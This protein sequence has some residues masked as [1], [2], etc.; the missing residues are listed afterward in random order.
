M[1]DVITKSLI[2][3]YRNADKV[4]N[5]QDKGRVAADVGQFTKAIHTASQLDNALGKGA[6]AA[7]SA[8]KNISQENK[9]LKYAAK[10]AK[11]ASQN[12]NPLLIGA[13][14]YRVLTAEDKATALRKETI[15]MSS[16]FGTEALMKEFLTSNTMNNFRSKIKNKNLKA[17][18]SIAEGVA[19]VCGSIAGSTLGYKVAD[20][21]YGEN[22]KTEIKED[23]IAKLIEATKAEKKEKTEKSIA[24]KDEYEAEFFTPM[25]EKKVLA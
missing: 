2:F 17:L 20:A 23:K 11:W 12:V 4:V 1:Y 6:Q 14:G 9:A 5:T 25:N 8:V 13:A 10:S 15:G 16:M 7:V 18:L 22:Q 21:I 24:P 19:F 3:G